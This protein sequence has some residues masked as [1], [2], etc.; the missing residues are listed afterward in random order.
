MDINVLKYFYMD[1]GKENVFVKSYFIRVIRN[2]IIDP[3]TYNILKD[4]L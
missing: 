2:G 1:N 3:N 4:R